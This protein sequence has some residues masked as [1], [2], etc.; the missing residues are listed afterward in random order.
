M[1]IGQGVDAHKLVPG[2]RLV[3]GGVEIRCDRGLEG[4]SDG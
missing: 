2:R 1:R 3:L 4:H